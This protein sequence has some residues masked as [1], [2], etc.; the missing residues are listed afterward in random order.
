MK[1]LFC[2]PAVLLLVS[3]GSSFAQEWEI[4][5]LGGYAFQTKLKAKSSAGEADAGFK[6]SYA[7]G[8]L[9]G[10]DLHK[11]LGGEV[12][13]LYRGGSAYLESGGE[14]PSFSARQHLVHY[15]LLWHF[16]DRGQKVRP[17]IAFGAGI[18]VVEGTGTE[19][20]YQP[21]SQFAVFT[22]RNQI[23]P[24]ISLGGG[25]K[26]KVGEKA[27]MRVEVRDYMSTR[28]DEVIAPVPGGKLSGWMNDF[29]PAVGIGFNW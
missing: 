25:V 5:G 16:A 18:K 4:S 17:F 21:L 7:V 3:A 10:N 29:I 9:F 13:Y 11:R 12:R 20:A 22:A 6:D 27:I 28:P 8:V 26:F 19:K 24:L 15:D 23:L 14:K 1:K 2:L